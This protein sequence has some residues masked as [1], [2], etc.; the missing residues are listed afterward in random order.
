M[1]PMLGSPD[2]SS[3]LRWRLWWGPAAPVGW[4]LVYLTFT[5]MRTARLMEARWEALVEEY[6]DQVEFLATTFGQVMRQEHPEVGSHHSPG[7]IAFE[8]AAGD[9]TL[10]L[11]LQEPVRT[12]LGW[13]GATLEA[14]RAGRPVR[15][16]A[17]DLFLTFARSHAPEW[18][19]RMGG[20]PGHRAA[21]VD[22]AVARHIAVAVFGP[23]PAPQPPR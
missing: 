9:R 16:V 5:A 23:A 3:P 1:E 18:V 21:I 2:S 15:L 10:V 13:G 17:H 12:R 14:H 7:H 20:W 22:P 8:T 19:A 6:P 11:H 4:T